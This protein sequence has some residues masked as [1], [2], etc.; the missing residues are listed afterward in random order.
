MT[1]KNR[2][3]DN[4]IS[5]LIC[6]LY[7]R[8]KLN[9]FMKDKISTLIDSLRVK[10]PLVLNITNYVA[11]NNSANAILAV[12]GSPI[13]SKTETEMYDMAKICDS[14]V[15]NIGTLEVD[16]IE[17]MLAAQIAFNK[18]NK[19]VILDPVGAGASALRNE[20]ISK[21][22]TNGRVN[23]IRGNGS[24]IIS[25]AGNAT[26]TK[27]V[28]SQD[29]STDAIQS[30]KILAQQHNCVVCISGETDVIVSRDKVA[31]IDNGDR[32]MTKVTALGCSC[33]AIL[34]A[35][36][37]IGN[38]DDFLTAISGCSMMCVC[39]EIAVKISNGPGSLQVNLLDTL[40]NTAGEE[41]VELLRLTV[42]DYQR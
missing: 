34:G 1:S 17:A 8:V 21:I 18:Q 42:E 6:F 11:M 28:D 4:L 5:E 9:L 37:G 40:Y 35:F 13:M 36:A 14:L 10:N 23:F 3:N 24:E 38:S 39:G 20:T 22:L 32:L 33:S 16:S 31:Y 30:A 25:V 26:K 12:G 41:V 15:I 29:G 2:R 19:P 27:G 7:L